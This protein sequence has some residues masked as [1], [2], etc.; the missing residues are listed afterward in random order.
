MVLYFVGVQGSAKDI[1]EKYDP[2]EIH[3]N[4]RLYDNGDFV[5]GFK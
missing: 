1:V 4:S 2:E 3:G 5:C